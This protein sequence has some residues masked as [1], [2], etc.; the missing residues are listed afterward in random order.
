ML[1]SKP[2]EGEFREAVDTVANFEFD[3]DVAGPG[4]KLEEIAE[5]T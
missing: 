2:H 5:F 1:E 3:H 4:Q